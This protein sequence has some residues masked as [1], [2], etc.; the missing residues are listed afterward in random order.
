MEE[1]ACCVVGVTSSFRAEG[2]SVTAINLAYTLA[3]AQK[4]VLLLEGDMR[5]PTIARRL[6]LNATPGLSN[7][8]AGM[9]TWKEC[10]QVYQSSTERKTVKVLPVFDYIQKMRSS[11]CGSITI[12]SSSICPR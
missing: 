10:C 9:C 11:G 3:E 4:R 12:S 6:E 2:K 5:L 7:L 8:L 1:D